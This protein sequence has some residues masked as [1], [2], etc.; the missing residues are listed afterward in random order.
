M[1]KEEPEAR[2]I[3]TQAAPAPVNALSANVVERL[4]FFLRARVLGVEVPPDL[5]YIVYRIHGPLDIRKL[6][7]AIEELAE[8]VPLFRQEFCV[9]E[10][11]WRR[12]TRDSIHHEELCAVTRISAAGATGRIQ[13]ILRTISPLGRAPLAKF[14]IMVTGEHE[15]VLLFAAPH[16]LADLWD[17]A[18]IMEGVATAYNGGAHVTLEVLDSSDRPSLD[19]DWERRIAYW[20]TVLGSEPLAE[21]VF[22]WAASHD[23]MPGTAA[24]S[25]DEEFSLGPAFS[26]LDSGRVRSQ[27]VSLAMLFML[28]LWEILPCYVANATTVPVVYVDANRRRSQR[29]VLANTTDFLPLRLAASEESSPWERIRAVQVLLSAAYSHRLPY[30]EIV[31]QLCPVRYANVPG[32]PSIFLNVRHSGIVAGPELRLAGLETEEMW[33][34][35]PML[36]P[37]LM[38]SADISGNLGR[39]GLVTAHPAV[40]RPVAHDMVRRWRHGFEQIVLSLSRDH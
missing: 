37:N 9:V 22:T 7:A 31:R 5:T 21:P 18:L 39:L 30:A 34:D 23:G 15:H 3:R 10:G 28:A 13:E 19:L 38:F 20:R 14:Q 12:S 17:T 11:T 24:L 35:P 16:A 8:R 26:I 4:M 6:R 36:L 29:D 1:R 25:A 40:T 27:G 2:P 33:V 32:L